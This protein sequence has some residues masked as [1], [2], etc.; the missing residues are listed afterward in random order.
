MSAPAAR[1][2]QPAQSTEPT[3]LVLE[4]SGLTVESLQERTLR[5]VFRDAELALPAGEVVLLV[6][7]SGSGKTLFTK[8]LVGLL[9]PGS[10]ALSIAPTSHMRVHLRSGEQCEVLGTSRYPARLRGA[11][12]YLFQEHALF[13]ELSVEDNIRF[14]GTLAAEPLPPAVFAEQLH[15]QARRLKL[16]RQLR[17]P[18]E[19][20]SGGQRQRTALLRMLALRPEI[21]I[22]DEPTSGLDPDAAGRVAA[23]IR[24]TQHDTPPA[25]RPGLSLVVTHDYTNLLGVADRVVLIHPARGFTVYPIRNEQE[26]ERLGAELKRA[27]QQWEPPRPRPLSRAQVRALR[28]RAEWYR[29]RSAPGRLWDLLRSTPRL[30]ARSLRWHRRFAG[31]LA[32]LL[33]IDAVPFTALAGVAIGLVVSYFSLNSVPEQLQ[34]QAEPIFI[35]EIIQGLGLALYQILAPLLAAICLTARSG[36]AIA[37]HLSHMERSSQLDALRVLGMPPWALLGDKV[38]LSFMIGMPLHAAI[39]FAAAS[40]ASLV[41]VLMTRPLVTWYT[42]TASYVGGLGEHWLDLPYHGTG[43]L[44]AK[45]VPAGLLCALLAWREGTRPK[46]S[47]RDVNRAITRAIMQ[48]I[49]AVITVFFLVLLLEVRR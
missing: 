47:A 30:Y 28:Q 16:E 5:T 18:I 44:L 29:F 8:L 43:W 42:F 36:A 20:L 39:C 34:A 7:P 37:G 10:P 12:G 11:I 33:V 1:T 31:S 15:A 41:V 14:G 2:E 48:G 6:G 17:S 40:F 23:L 25:L 4:V 27:L 38:A 19:V 21:L 3:R 13:D 35:E 46:A 24:Q 9:G 49:L 32:R 26:R 45:L 22:Y